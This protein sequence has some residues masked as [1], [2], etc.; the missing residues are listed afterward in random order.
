M[1]GL[2]HGDIY[3]LTLCS[4]IVPF[5]VQGS[6][7]MTP[8]RSHVIVEA[9]IQSSNNKVFLVLSRAVAD[10]LSDRPHLIL[11]EEQKLPVRHGGLK[12]YEPGD[13]M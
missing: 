2:P 8:F 1:D 11:R 9:P 5:P 4:G 12:D 13:K 6:A 3:F 10:R 7:S